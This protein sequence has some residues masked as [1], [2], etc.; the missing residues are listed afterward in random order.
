MKFVIPTLAFISSCVFAADS[1]P[2]DS[3]PPSQAQTTAVVSDTVSQALQQ[4]GQAAQFALKTAAQAL[5]QDQGKFAQAEDDDRADVPRMFLNDGAGTL[6][7]IFGASARTGGQPL[8]VRNGQPASKTI[9]DLQEDLAIM[10]RILAKAV[11]REGRDAAMGI[12]LSALP[13]S[14]HPQSLY[15]DGYGALFL[16]NVKFPLVPPSVKEDEKTE[17][18]HD[19]T[20]DETKR[21]LY[22][23]RPGTI[24]LWNAQGADAGVEY[25]A[26]QV[27]DLKK[28]LLQGLKN[29]THLRDVRP[30]ESVTIAVTGSSEGGGAMRVRRSKKATGGSAIGADGYVTTEVTHPA[31]RETTLVIRV[32]KSDVDAFAKGDLDL[33]QF[34]KVASISAY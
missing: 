14:R 10:S 29:A 3:N 5:S 30:D 34:K 17:K 8:I 21:E 18:P 15:L 25:N 28:E 22:G 27:E 23:Q 11:G 19:T 32:K 31:N 2:P 24:R 20:W 4:A 33:D 6:E 7:H 12:V 1:A 9:S 26:E 13:G 16:L